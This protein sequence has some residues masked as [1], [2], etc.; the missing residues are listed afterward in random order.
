MG[1][2]RWG[3]GFLIIQ[4]LGCGSDEP[5]APQ[6]GGSGGSAAGTG[7]AAGGSK[8]GSGGGASG[9]SSGTYAFGTIGTGVVECAFI[10]DA[11]ECPASTACCD[12][13]PKGDTSCVSSLAECVCE[14]GDPCVKV[15]CDDPADCPGQVCCGKF[16][17]VIGEFSGSSC[18]PSCDPVLDA[19]ICSQE[20]D[21]TPAQNCLAS[22][23]IGRRCF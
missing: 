6:T 15:G 23:S 7:G 21:C 17:G 2:A 18:K 11:N 12:K 3:L 8:A 1:N 22:S 20:S 16:G 14:P 9:N 19:V 13:F 10:G 4:A 5:P